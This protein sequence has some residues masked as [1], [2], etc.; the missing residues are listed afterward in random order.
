[1]A[2]RP[3]RSVLSL[4]GVALADRQFSAHTARLDLE[5]PRGEVALLQVEDEHDA[6]ML[7][8]LCLGLADPGAGQVR[9]LGVDWTTRT[10]RERFHR[11]RRI[12]AVVQTDVWPSHMTVLE[13]VLVARAYHFHQPQAEVIADATELARLFAL[14]RPQSARG[15]G[16]I[17]HR[18]ARSPSVLCRVSRITPRARSTSSL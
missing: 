16:A 6:A 9:F 2:A 17:H 11:R 15:R 3:G 14:A 7:V 4:Q 18:T 13:S 5:L 8:D 1:M 12:G 10:P